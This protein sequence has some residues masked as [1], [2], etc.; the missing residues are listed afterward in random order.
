M[1]LSIRGI[2]TSNFL[3]EIEEDVFNEACESLEFEPS[4]FKKFTPEQ[5]VE[6]RSVLIDKTYDFECN[7]YY[8]EIHDDHSVSVDE[9]HI[10][11]DDMTVVLF[12]KD[13]KFHSI[14]IE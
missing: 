4:Q 9:V 11:D 3:L 10:S 7:I 8:Q 13:G 14:D 6:L 12:E 5:W 2:V 1:E